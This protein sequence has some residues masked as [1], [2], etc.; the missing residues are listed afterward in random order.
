MTK[1]SLVGHVSLAL[2]L[3]WLLAVPTSV[4]ADIAPRWS[5]AELTGFSDVVLTGDVVSVVAGT[6]GS[7]AI[8]TYV[9]IAVDEVLKGPVV[10]PPSQVV[11]KQLGGTLGTLTQVVWGQALFTPG[12]EVVAFLE[13][14]PR[15]ATLY[16]SAL[17]QGKWTIQ[18]NAVTGNALVAT[19]VPAAQGLALAVAGQQVSPGGEARAL[20]V[21]LDE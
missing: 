21:L 11:V 4:V 5:V 17:W 7:D 15:D 3:L 16:T 12:Q 2:H 8:Y 9:T 19:Q 10:T 13:V 18:R 6:D 20:D 14:R 1:L